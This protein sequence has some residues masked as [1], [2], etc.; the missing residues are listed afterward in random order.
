MRVIYGNFIKINFFCFFC[1]N[2]FSDGP[3]VETIYGFVEGVTDSFVQ[4]PFDDSKN[5]FLDAFYGI[6]FARPPIG[7]L[8]SNF[9]L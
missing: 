2:G 5:G 7:E 1:K 6:P 4:K 9:I 8:R 3:L